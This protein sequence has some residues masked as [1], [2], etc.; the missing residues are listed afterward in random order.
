M[1]PHPDIC[2]SRFYSLANNVIKQ[3]QKL[4]NKLIEC[5]LGGYRRNS[6]E[7]VMLS[8]F[9]VDKVVADFHLGAQRQFNLVPA[10]DG[11]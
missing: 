7:L 8:V 2:I 9:I 5:P 3:V 6:I 4:V 11:V 10:F 1:G